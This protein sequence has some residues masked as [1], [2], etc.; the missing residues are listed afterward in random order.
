[1]KVF[2]V[3]ALPLILAAQGQGPGARDNQRPSMPAPTIEEYNPKTV[4]VVPRTDIKRA[5][6]PFVDIHMHHRDTTP[7]YLEKLI[8]DMDE[9][10]MRAMINSP[11]NGSFG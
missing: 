1:M 8:K 10:N 6:F 3:L 2:V 9:L 4:L 7:A 5:K 11:V